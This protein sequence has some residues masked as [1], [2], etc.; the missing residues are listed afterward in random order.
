MKAAL[1]ADTPKP[2]T[3]IEIY[4][5]VLIVSYK[6]NLQKIALKGEKTY[7]SKYCCTVFSYVFII[8]HFKW[9][10]ISHISSVKGS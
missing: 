9:V 8:Y 4:M 7:S 2:H 10:D 5:R 6:A 1:T 3:D